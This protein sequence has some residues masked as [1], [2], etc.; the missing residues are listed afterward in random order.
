MRRTTVPLVTT[1][2]CGIAAVA[3][4]QSYPSK[5]VSII[6]PYPPGGITDITGRHMV[7]QHQA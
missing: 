6:V 4:A 7:P 3:G 5:A 2:L 1:I